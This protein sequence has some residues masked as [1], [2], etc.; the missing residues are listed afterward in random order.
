MSGGTD[1]SKRSQCDRMLE[2]FRTTTQG[3]T[4]LEALTYFRT[5]DFRRRLCDLKDRGFVF[6]YVWE[7][8]SPGVKVRRHW[9]IAEPWAPGKAAA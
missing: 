5:M 1:P 8:P 7:Y 6:R 2:H 4:S 3:L 9:L